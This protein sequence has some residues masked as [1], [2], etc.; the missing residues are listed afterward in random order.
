MGSI[1]YDIIVSTHS[2]DSHFNFISPGN[3]NL[4]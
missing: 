3:S 4:L 2:D 1:G